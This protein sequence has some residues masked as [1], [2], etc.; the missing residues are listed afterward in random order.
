M[1]SLD[2]GCCQAEISLIALSKFAE[3]ALKT[4][5]YTELYT[6]WFESPIPPKN[7]SLEY[8][9]PDRLKELVKAAAQ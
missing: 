6:K 3:P 9:M 2:L 7:V 8:P 4:G 5:E 1:S